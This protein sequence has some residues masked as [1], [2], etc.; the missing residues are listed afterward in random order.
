MNFSLYIAKRYLFTKSGSNAINIMTFIAATGV[1]VTAAALFIVLSGFGGL[2][3]FSLGFSSVVDPD[4]KVIANKGKSFSISQNEY[5]ALNGIK[6]IV[7]TSKIIEERAI[8]EFENKNFLVTLKGVDEHFLKVSKIDSM[9]TLGNWFK[10]GTGQIVSGWGIAHNLSFGVLDY[11]KVLRLYVPKPGKGQITSVKGAFNS[12]TAVN[13]GIFQINEDLDNTYV[14][15]DIV[16]ARYLLD[17]GPEQVSALEIK[18]NP[19][20]DENE[21]RS[22]I[23]KILGDRTIIKNKAQLNDALYKMLNTENLV[24]YLIFTLIV[25]IALF[26]VVGALIMMVLDKKGSLHTLFNLGATIKD[27]RRIF[28]LQG[29]LMTVF[30]GMVGLVLGV[31]IVVAQ[32]QFSL[33]MLTASLPYPV[34]LNALNAFI[35][36][37]TISI[38][39]IVASKLASSRITENLVNP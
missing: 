7:S 5:D 25:I 23:E 36:L 28:F 27:I 33:V 32:K 15:T 3:E 35:V 4:L 37:S 12:L 9:V 24:V 8:L 18:R 29:S 6:G 16:N 31:G 22:A 38:L 10:P 39:G 21:I 30:G 2:K 17:Y 1:V 20:V 19:D 34:T 13:I 14:F 26:N 11:G